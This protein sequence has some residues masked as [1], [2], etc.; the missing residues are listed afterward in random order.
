VEFW[1]RW[2]ISLTKFFTRYLYI[3]IGG[4]RKGQFRT[5]LNTI[6]VFLVSGLWHGA[7]WTFV[8][9]GGVHGLLLVTT[10]AFQK[11]IQK[12]PRWSNWCLT[13][14]L[15]NL[16]W[17]PFR[18]GSFSEVRQIFRNLIS[19]QYG[20]IHFS[21]LDNFRL[22]EIKYMYNMLGLSAIPVS[23]YLYVLLAFGVSFW[24]IFWCKNLEQENIEFRPTILKSISCAVLL[25]WCMCSFPSISTFIYQNF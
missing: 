11:Q 12:I 22:T 16:T 13:F 18:A 2:H 21:V 10:K 17:I 20:G 6:I 3:P 1:D 8:F 9:W 5:Y 4:N 19:F 14:M 25:V 23:N 24:A 15:V 7:D